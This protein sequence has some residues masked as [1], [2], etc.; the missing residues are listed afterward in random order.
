MTHIQCI[1]H[2]VP[3]LSLHEKQCKH[4]SQKTD[5]TIFFSS[6][7]ISNVILCSKCHDMHFVFHLALL[8]IVMCFNHWLHIELALSE[9]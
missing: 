2:N 1:S 5:F 4:W 6:Q 9:L 8:M 3:L 7:T